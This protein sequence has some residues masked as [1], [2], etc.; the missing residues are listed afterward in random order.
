MMEFCIQLHEV[1]LHNSFYVRGMQ[2]KIFWG[3]VEEKNTIDYNDENSG[4][5]R[6]G[7]ARWRTSSEMSDEWLIPVKP[8]W[9]MQAD[10]G[11][12][13]WNDK[14]INNFKIITE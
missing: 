7:Q 12:A 5:V 3:R 14:C 2:M 11:Q 13:S 10:G 4:P 8:E 9:R 1:S 6:A